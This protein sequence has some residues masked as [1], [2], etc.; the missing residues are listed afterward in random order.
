MS[1]L[2]LHTLSVAGGL[3]AL[4]AQPG[5]D[6]D[7]AGDVAFI[8]DWRPSL[9]ITLTTRAELVVAHADKLGADVRE[10]GALWE[11]WPIDDFCAPNADAIAR[12]PPISGFARSALQGHGRVLV[13]CKAGCGRSGMVALRLMIEAGEPAVEALLRLRKIRPCAI[14]TDAQMRWAVTGLLPKEG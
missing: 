1:D 8:R 9:V 13:H 2:I 3:L 7:Y 14:E 5:L 4:S 12:W 10:S 11:H 6:G